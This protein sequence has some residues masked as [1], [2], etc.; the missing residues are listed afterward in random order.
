MQDGTCPARI[1]ITQSDDLLTIYGMSSTREQDTAINFKNQ[2]W[3][4]LGPNDKAIVL[5]NR[6]HLTDGL[7]VCQPE[8]IDENNWISNVGNLSWHGCFLNDTPEAKKERKQFSL[9]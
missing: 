7:D 8:M 9:H 5:Y 4:K 3:E 6:L 2:V 1:L